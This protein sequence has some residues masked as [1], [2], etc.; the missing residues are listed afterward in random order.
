M[1]MICNQL[2]AQSDAF[3]VL[4]RELRTE[5]ACP[6][7]ESLATRIVEAEEADFHWDARVAERH[8]GAYWSEEDDNE[9]ELD[10]VA[11][12]SLLRDRWHV[13]TLVV[14]GEGRAVA[15]LGRVSFGARHEAA[16]ALERAR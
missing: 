13:A 11:V 14:D 16:A 9:D 8:L 6:D 7:V 5:F 3:H 12:L 15:M 4:V 2:G 1:T 10:R